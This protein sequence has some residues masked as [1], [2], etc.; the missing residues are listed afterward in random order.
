MSHYGV[1]GTPTA[2]SHLPSISATLIENET[3]E[4]QDLQLRPTL[5]NQASTSSYPSPP[6]SATLIE[7]TNRIKEEET[8][9]SKNSTPCLL[10]TTW[11]SPWTTI[12]FTKPESTT[13]GG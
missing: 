3:Y 12:G 11:R 2:V 5:S 8:S 9:H 1:I 13:A 6:R 10:L 4:D 7:L